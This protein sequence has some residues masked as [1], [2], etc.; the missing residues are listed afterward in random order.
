MTTAVVDAPEIEDP[1]SEEE[2]AQ[3]FFDTLVV[4]RPLAP[5]TGTA[6][7]EMAV[8]SDWAS[9]LHEVVRPNRRPRRR[10]EARWVPDPRGQQTL[11]CIWV[12]PTGA[13]ASAPSVQS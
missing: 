10:L 7:L 3:V 5:E 13:A 8:P 2:L 1:E 9:S 12:P 11:I 4:D 6:V